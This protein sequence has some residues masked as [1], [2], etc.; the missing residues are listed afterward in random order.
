[1]ASQPDDQTTPSV[2][3]RGAIIGSSLGYRASNGKTG[4]PARP[5]RSRIARD[6]GAARQRLRGRRCDSG[7]GCPLYPRSYSG[8]FC[9]LPS[10]LVSGAR[11]RHSM[12]EADQ[13]APMMSNVWTV[14]ADTALLRNAT[15]ATN[16]TNPTV[17]RRPGRVAPVAAYRVTETAASDH[18]HPIKRQRLYIRPR[19]HARL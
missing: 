11:P 6:A 18:Y 13:H 2:R 15:T 5:R 8:Y 7:A 12:D 17:M 10:V 3:L 16:V 14:T 1:M 4:A 19:E 9:V